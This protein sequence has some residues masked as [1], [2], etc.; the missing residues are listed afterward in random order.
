MKRI[1]IFSRDPGGANAIIPL[2]RPLRDSG[3]DVYLYG[4]DFALDKYR[5]AGLVATNIADMIPVIT[6]PAL[7]SFI[8]NIN[9]DIVITGTSADDA[10]EKEIWKICETDGIPSM[11]VVDQ[12]CNYG[13][14][15]SQFGV[16]EIINYDAGKH[17][18]RLPTQIIALDDFACSEMV[19]EGLP[20]ER[21]SV[22]GQPYFE[23]V[24]TH[25][26][27]A[28]EMENYCRSIAIGA[29]DFVV[30]FA[31]EP[32]TTTYGEQEALHYWGYTEKTI[33][34]SLIGALE[35]I[36]TDYGR[37]IVLLLRAHPKEG[38]DHFVNILTNCDRIHW[39]F[40]TNS[41]PWTMMQRADLVCGMSS[42]FLVESVILRRPTI[43]VQI[44]L[45]R[46]DPFVLARRGIMHSVRSEVELEEQ[47]RRIIIAG[48]LELPRFEITP[49]PVER[50][51]AEVERQLWRN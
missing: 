45:R 24:L 33:L 21:I 13:L 20:E 29:D 26:S 37:P 31:S 12:W 27:N 18:D 49:N 1:L 22:C 14:R 19:A 25:R 39:R 41:S 50:I 46:D 51:I 6:E 15:F 42:M 36:A 17:L 35:K 30:V 47:L 44:G 7:A 23:T 11:A 3:Y 34:A 10:T 2:V 48:E 43:S 4:K 5:H 38:C 16:D 32:I 28:E 8:A 9:P 40:D